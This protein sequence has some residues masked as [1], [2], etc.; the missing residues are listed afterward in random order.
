ML[1]LA[2]E[3]IR[4][5]EDAVLRVGQAAG[6][7][8]R[9]AACQ[10]IASAR[11]AGTRV[12]ASGPDVSAAPE[13]YLRAGADLTL[14]GEGLSAL[15]DLVPRLSAELNAPGGELIQGLSGAAT[16]V[17]NSLVKINGAK[18]LPAIPH[19]GTPNGLESE[20]AAWDLVDIERYRAAWQ[21]AHGYFSLNM[22]ASRG[23]SFRCAWCAK[24]IWGN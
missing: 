17:Q 2:Q 15:L 14:K 18:V 5:V 23:C 4:I 22:A 20:I 10:M 21:K 8:M 9:R 16:L 13:Q 24:P 7:K 3:A 19:S 6:R 1:G 11:R 12:V